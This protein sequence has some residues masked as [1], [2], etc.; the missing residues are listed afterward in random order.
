MFVHVGM[1]LNGRRV[2]CNRAPVAWDEFTRYLQHVT[3]S[4]TGKTQV[5]TL[6]R[7]L[8]IGAGTQTTLNVVTRFW[9]HTWLRECDT[10]LRAHVD[11]CMSATSYASGN[12][13]EI[14]V[15]RIFTTWVKHASARY[16]YIV[17]D[18]DAAIR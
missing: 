12:G 16:I 10:W 14:C 5:T 4:H 1:F 3:F 7:I 2:I 9:S 17:T 6:C 13:V 18:G 15:Y 8:Q 11:T